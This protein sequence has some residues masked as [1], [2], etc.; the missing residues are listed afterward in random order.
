MTDDD[1]KSAPLQFGSWRDA[2]ELRRW[3]FARRTPQQRL[4]WLV[5]A[6]TIAY[7]SGAL[8]LEAPGATTPDAATRGVATAG[9]AAAGDATAGGAAAG[10]AARQPNPA[11][12][13]RP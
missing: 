8:A 5:E 11:G 13:Q 3:S 6:L 4:D 2:E 10:D 7:T 9:G 12:V 1:S